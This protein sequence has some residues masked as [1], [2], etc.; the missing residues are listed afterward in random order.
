MVMRIQRVNAH[1]ALSTVSGTY[2]C[3]Q[4]IVVISS[5]V[6]EIVAINCMVR[7][8][9]W[10]HRGKGESHQDKENWKML[11]FFLLSFVGFRAWR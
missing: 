10:G 1:S 6:V 8:T 4:K 11:L 3:I 2:S 9:Y 5:R 7:T